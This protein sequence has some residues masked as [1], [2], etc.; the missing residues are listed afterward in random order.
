[1]KKI[2]INSQNFDKNAVE[3]YRLSELILQ[4]NAAKEIA[5]LIRSKL[6]LGS[7]ILF[8]CGGGNNASDAIATS[9]MLNGD[10]EC[11][12]FFTTKN[13]NSNCITQLKIAN[14]LGVKTA[15]KIDDFSCVV[16]G[17]FGS[18]LNRAMDKN[19]VDIINNINNCNALKIAVDCPSGLCANGSIFGTCFKANFTV[20][21]GVRKLCL[22]SDLAKDFIGEIILGNLGLS[23]SKFSNN[24]SDFLLEICDLQLPK[25]NILNTNKGDFGHAFIACG[26][27]EGAAKITALSALNMGAGLV[28]VVSKENIN[29]DK[30]IMQKKEFL[31]ANAIALGMGL[32][33]SKIDID[34]ISN[35]P[36]VIDADMFYRNEV[37]EF[38]N[39]QNSILTPHPKEFSSLLNLVGMGNFEIKD[40]QNNRFELTREFSKNFRSILVLKGANTIIAKDGILYISN[41]GSPLLSVGGSGDALA[42]I[43]LAYL[44]QGY[45]PLNS[46]IN[47]TLAHAKTALDYKKNAYSFT[48][49]DII[50]GIKCL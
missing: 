38:V 25:R 42:G 39:L 12:L 35:L 21:M 7:K 49:N 16:D 8:L 41:L 48:T 11:E 2:Y 40:I 1:M 43:I 44:A 19:I 26:D 4:E 34:N 9:R 13:L 15:D 36:I 30:Q 3:I 33:A 31:G 10:Y 46:A 50:E 14:N 27:M 18:G 17:I 24:L 45:T 5:N 22:Y 37:L 28:S 29:L 32:G 23:E 6:E 47:G 20:S